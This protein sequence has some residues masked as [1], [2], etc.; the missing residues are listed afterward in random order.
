MRRAKLT[1][2]EFVECCAKERASLLKMYMNPRSGSRVAREIAS[3]ALSGEQKEVMKSVV[4]GLLT[5]V[6][7][8]V[9][10]GLDGAAPIGGR[11]VS[12][13]LLDEEGNE[14]TGEL[15]GLAWEHFHGDD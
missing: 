3:L 14:L 5:D 11:Q 7:Y 12:Y 6:F 13:Q 9:L 15:E 1:P 4:G 10:L 8:T 2:E